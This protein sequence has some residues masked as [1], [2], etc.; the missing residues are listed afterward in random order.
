VDGRFSTLRFNSFD[1]PEV[2]D[3]ILI[4][5]V[6]IRNVSIRLYSNPGKVA[7]TEHTA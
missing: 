7:G 4:G 1:H 3:E 5:F 2:L 6:M